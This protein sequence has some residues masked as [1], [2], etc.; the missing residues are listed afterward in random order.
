M[1]RATSLVLT[2]CLVRSAPGAP[3]PAKEPEAP[4]E[5]RKAQLE[6]AKAVYALRK[7]QYQAGTIVLESVQDWSRRVFDATLAVSGS[8]EER[9]AACKWYVEETKSIEQVAKRRFDA[10]GATVADWKAAEYFRIEAE[11][12]LFKAEAK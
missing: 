11:I 5:L 7:A 4:L 12:L 9:V 8:R 10:G 6:A 2:L 3:I 1:I